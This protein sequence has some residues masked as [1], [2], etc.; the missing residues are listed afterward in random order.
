MIEMLQADFTHHISVYGF[1]S[2]NEVWNVRFALWR[3]QRFRAP[4][5]CSHVDLRSVTYVSEALTASIF[6]DQVLFLGCLD[7]EQGGSKL[8][9]NVAS[10]YL[11]SHTV[12]HRG[13]LK[14][15]SYSVK[16]FRAVVL[17]FARHTKLVFGKR[18]K[19]KT[20][21]FSVHLPTLY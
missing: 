1:G 12:S 2:T 8:H 16:R 21:S 6:R 3:L 17:P 15:S 14:S 13:R 5:V 7:C 10:Y 19:S 20:V 18:F 11:P 9:R 4:G